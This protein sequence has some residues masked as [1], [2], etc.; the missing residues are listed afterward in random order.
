MGNIET[1]TSNLDARPIAQ[2]EHGVKDPAP[3]YTSARVYVNIM[4]A[5]EPAKKVKRH[6]I[7]SG[8][9]RF[10]KEP[11]RTSAYNLP[12]WRKCAC[13]RVKD[14]SVAD[15]RKRRGRNRQRRH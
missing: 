3:A 4:M 2:S 11:C 6:V 9:R 12:A 10:S 15:P 13:R 5:G 14:R 1:C 7:N 8:D